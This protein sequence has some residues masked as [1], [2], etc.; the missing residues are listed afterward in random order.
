V[1]TAAALALSLFLEGQLAVCQQAGQQRAELHG[2][3]K[4]CGKA[5]PH[6]LQRLQ[7]LQAHGLGIHALGKKGGTGYFSGD[8]LGRPEA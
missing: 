6:H 4:L 1:A 8:V 5:R 3:D 7:I 2:N